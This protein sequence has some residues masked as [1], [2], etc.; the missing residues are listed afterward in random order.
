M[1]FYM[2]KLFH[3]DKSIL[4]YYTYILKNTKLTNKNRYLL[5]YVV[6][7]TVIQNI[8]FITKKRLSLN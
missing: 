4:L 2:T 3:N 6:I 7:K 5:V 8:C 1:F